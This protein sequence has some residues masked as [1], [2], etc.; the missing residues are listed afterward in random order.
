MPYLVGRLLS[1]VTASA[2]LTLCASCS[3][4]DI[5]PFLTGGSSDPTV[6]VVC[7]P[8]VQ[9]SDEAKQF[10]VANVGDLEVEGDGTP[11]AE[12]VTQQIAL[13]NRELRAC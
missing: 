2:L 3:L 11:G 13:K 8:P 6:V 1:V 10:L 9:L 7:P 5:V 12:E 4:A